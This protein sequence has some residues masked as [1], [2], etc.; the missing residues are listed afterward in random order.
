MIFCLFSEA[1]ARVVL[2]NDSSGKKRESETPTKE[3]RVEFIWSKVPGLQL[4][5][6]TTKLFHQ[7]HVSGNLAKWGIPSL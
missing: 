4:K 7:E 2:K 5:V 3:P 6:F 1:V